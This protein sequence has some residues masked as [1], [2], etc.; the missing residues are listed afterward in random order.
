[1]VL[2]AHTFNP[3]RQKQSD[4][5]EFKARVDYIASSRPVKRACLKKE[6]LRAEVA[7]LAARQRKTLSRAHSILRV[8]G[9]RQVTVRP[10]LRRDITFP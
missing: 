6:E 3:R 10:P 7:V 5:R 8:E 2:K 9:H 1:M 4:L